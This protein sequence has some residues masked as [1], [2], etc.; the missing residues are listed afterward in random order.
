MRLIRR[1]R[2]VKNGVGSY[3]KP[4][5]SMNFFQTF[6]KKKEKFSKT[7]LKNWKIAALRFSSQKIDLTK[8]GPGRLR[9]V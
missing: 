1:R 7:N 9:T 8:N 4:Q 6:S 3:H 5:K 2:T